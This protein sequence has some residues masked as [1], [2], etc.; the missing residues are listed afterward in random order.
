MTDTRLASPRWLRVAGIAL[1]AAAASLLRFTPSFVLWRGLDLPAAAA[2]PAL[3]RAGDALRQLAHPLAYHAS[4][5]NRVIEWRLLFPIVGHALGLPPRLYLALPPLGCLLVLLYV[6]RLLL[7]QGLPVWDAF[8]ATAL[9]ATCSW[10]FVSTAWLAYFDAWYILGLLITVFGA[11][12]E[13]LAAILLTPWV[14]ERFVLTLPLCLVLRDRAAAA[15]GSPRSGTERWREAG[16]AVAALLP[17]IAIRLGAYAAHHDAVTGAYVQ[18]MTPGANL[19]FYPRGL[20]YGLRWAWVPVLA[21]LALEWR[22]GW[23]SFAVLFLTLGL[24]LAVNLLAANDLSR[25][26]SIALPVVILG[27]LLLHR[28][29]PGRLG[30]PLLTVCGLNL[31]F[32]AK[33]AVSTWTEDILPFPVE[34]ERARHPPA[35]L[36]ADYDGALNRAVADYQLGHLPEALTEANRAVQ[37]HPDFPEALYNRAVIRAAGG[38][39]TGAATDV[40]E[41]LR[42][43]APDWYGRAQAEAFLAALRARTAAPGGPAGPADR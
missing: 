19:R 8:A 9:A 30:G 2:D 32:P 35:V 40:E 43:T 10:F 17:W 33:H 31:L 11:P 14:D 3:N 5:N 37:L 23:R 29:F 41:V 42:V 4:A 1:L 20:W 7:R 24:T 25:S 12:G 6:A 13:M 18:G 27:V 34:F 28:R 36:D 22:S 26:V 21:W 39:F 15:A 38:D 16:V